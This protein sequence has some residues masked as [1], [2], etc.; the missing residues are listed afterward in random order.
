LGSIFD[1]AATFAT[2]RIEVLDTVTKEAVKFETV[3][4]KSSDEMQD[5]S[6]VLKPEV[7]SYLF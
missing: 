7:E 4:E 1:P 5:D 2:N 3:P 6:F